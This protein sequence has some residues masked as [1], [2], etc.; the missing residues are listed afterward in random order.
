MSTCTCPSRPHLI[1]HVL[2]TSCLAPCVTRTAANGNSIS[3]T[4][5]MCVLL[6]VSIT[7]SRREKPSQRDKR[8]HPL[9][10]PLTPFP[11]Q[12]TTKYILSAKKDPC[13]TIPCGYMFPRMMTMPSHS[14]AC[15]VS[16][17]SLSKP[18]FCGFHSVR[19][20]PILCH[21]RTLVARTL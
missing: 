1:S 2:E 3:K 18:V 20:H 9:S 7:T 15:A 19:L 12:C 17:T 21:R 11:C 14:S 6:G 16:Q 13:S 5:L 4:V 8:T 10:L